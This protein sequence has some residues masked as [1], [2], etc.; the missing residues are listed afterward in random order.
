MKNKRSYILKIVIGLISM[1][2]L[3]F[4]DQYTKFLA[5]THLKDKAPK[6]VIE[7]VFEFYYLQNKGAAWGMM[8]G[9]RIFFIVI[10]IIVIALIIWVYLR[11]PI[12]KKYFLMHT[13]LILAISGAIGNLIDRVVNGYVNDFLYFKLINFPIFNIADCYVVVG[14]ILLVILVMFVYTDDSD[15]EFLKLRK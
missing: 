15:F 11:T 1:A 14:G 6:V 7:N 12:E 10:T 5:V 9:Q 13:V 8:S 2:V 4:L 3:V